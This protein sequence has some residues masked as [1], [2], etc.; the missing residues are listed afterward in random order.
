VNFKY[1]PDGEVAKSF[2]K[3]DTFFRGIRGPVGSG[4]SV[5]C[6]VEVFRRALMQEKSPDGKRKSGGLSSE[7]QILSFALPRLRLGWTGF[8]KKIGVGFLGQFHIR[9]K[10]PRV[11]WSWK[12]YSLH[13]TDLKTLRNSSLRTNWHMD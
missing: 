5:A 1:K 3:D 2:M 12:L 13:S 7:T 9:T 4:K 8:R 11:T 6:S 10:L